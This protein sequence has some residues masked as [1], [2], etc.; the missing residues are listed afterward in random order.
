MKIN[1]ICSY[2]HVISFRDINNSLYIG[3]IIQRCFHVIRESMKDAG[4]ILDNNHIITISIDTREELFPKIIVSYAEV[5]D[6]KNI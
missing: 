5:I 2:Q 6:D 4:Q 1:N 3:N